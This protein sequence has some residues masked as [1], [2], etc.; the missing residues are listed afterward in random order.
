[1][2]GGEEKEH[3]TSTL[4]LVPSSSGVLPPPSRFLQTKILPVCKDQLNKG[5]VLLEADL[6][7]MWGH[8]SIQAFSE[9]CF[10]SI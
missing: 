9:A 8:F 5:S 6:I 4:P 10:S 7:L 1:M 3:A 2:K